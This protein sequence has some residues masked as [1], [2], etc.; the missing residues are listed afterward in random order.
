L[1]FWASCTFSPHGAPGQQGRL[2]GHPAN[3]LGGAGGGGRLPIEP[4][5]AFGGRL[6]PGNEAHQGRFAAAA[7]A[8]QA[9]KFARLNVQVD[10]FAGRGYGRTD[11][12]VLMNS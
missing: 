10:A 3:L 5:A 2:L 6:Q 1:I 11:G 12:S 7:D 9:H 8:H 4:D